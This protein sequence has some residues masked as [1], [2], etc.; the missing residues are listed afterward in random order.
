MWKFSFVW[1]CILVSQNEGKNVG[2][3]ILKIGSDRR[4][5]KIS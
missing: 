4:L 5:E 3:G 1:V 2:C